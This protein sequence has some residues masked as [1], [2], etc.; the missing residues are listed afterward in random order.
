MFFSNVFFELFLFSLAV[1]GIVMFDSGMF[2]K[3]SNAGINFKAAGIKVG[4]YFLIA[5]FFASLIYLNRGKDDFFKFAT[6]YFLEVSLS[7]DNVFVFILIFNYFNA[8]NCTRNRVLLYGVIGAFFLRGLFI[9]LGVAVIQKFAFMLSIFGLILVFTAIKILYHAFKHDGKEENFAKSKLLKIISKFTPI[10]PSYKG[11]QFT[12]IENHK[13]YLTTSFL[14]LVIVSIAD[15]L[16]AIDSIPAV[17]A[18]TRDIYI[19]YTSNILAILGLRSLFFVID[20]FVKLFEY[21]KHGL[22]IVLLV[23]GIKLCAEVFFHDFVSHNIPVWSMLVFS[24]AI[25]TISILL[26]IVK[27]KTK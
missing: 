20:R 17:F 3:K 26:S 18:V 5:V 7:I 9:I 21:L 13:I 12:L 27:N 19:I 8:S 14:I 4:F 11:S 23:I 6:A 10:H 22:G 16:F 1:F 24:S 25:F 2:A 15:V